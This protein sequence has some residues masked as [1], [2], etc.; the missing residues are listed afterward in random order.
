MLGLIDIT[1][2]KDNI[3]EF[4]HILIFLYYTYLI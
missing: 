3:G 1:N 2:Y 4:T